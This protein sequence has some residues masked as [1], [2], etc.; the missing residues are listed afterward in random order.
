MNPQTWPCAH[1][2]ETDCGNRVSFQGG[3]CYGCWSGYPTNI[4]T[5]IKRVVNANR[6][7]ADRRQD[8]AGTGRRAGEVPHPFPLRI[9]HQLAEAVHNL[10]RTVDRGRDPLEDLATID[11]LVVVLQQE[12]NNNP[13]KDK[14]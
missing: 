1:S 10:I 6:R 5:V 8:R 2:T 13:N 14:K 7:K 11:H 9:D 12:I 4:D 3:V